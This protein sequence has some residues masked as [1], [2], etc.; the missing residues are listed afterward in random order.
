MIDA[1]KA[2]AAALMSIIAMAAKYGVNRNP[3]VRAGKHGSKGPARPAGS[4]IAR[5]ADEC[6]I[7]KC[8]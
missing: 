4:K 5:M 2:Q 3:V 8:N 7:G 1:L 6:R